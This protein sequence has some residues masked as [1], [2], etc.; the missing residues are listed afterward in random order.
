MRRPP[1]RS[2]RGS[3]TPLMIGFAVVVALLIVV[4][5]DA[6]AVFL[7][8]QQLRALADQ[9]ALAAA[10]EDFARGVYSGTAADPSLPDP[11]PAG[12]RASVVAALARERSPDLAGSEVRV[13]VRGAT[14]VV[15]LR[16][17]YRLP[18]HLPG[19][20]TVVPVVGSGSA[21]MVLGR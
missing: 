18:L 15:E 10:E 14:V 17:R 3:V 5:V 13:A 2:E 1:V 20:E 9:A 7:R 16:S 6:S 11:D 21:R 12:I 8:R 4:V 19:V